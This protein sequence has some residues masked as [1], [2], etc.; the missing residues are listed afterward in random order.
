MQDCGVDEEQLRYCLREGKLVAKQV[1][2]GEMRY[3]KEVELKFMK[4]IV[5]YCI[6]KDGEERIITCYPIRKKW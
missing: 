6:N 3:S 2:R 5:V 4:I 1:V